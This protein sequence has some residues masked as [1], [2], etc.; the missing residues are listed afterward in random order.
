MANAQGERKQVTVLF[1]DISGFTALSETLD[2]E[3]VTELVNRFFGALNAPI[4]KYDGTI[5][6]FMGDAVMV[7]F[8]APAAHE[9]DPERAIRC[10]LEMRDAFAAEKNAMRAPDSL[11]LHIGI[12]T[13]L[14]V[15][16]VVGTESK[17]EYTVIGDTVN[18]ASRLKDQAPRGEIYVSQD[19]YRF[20]ERL[21]DFRAVGSLEV[22][23]KSQP[24]PT[25]QVVES[26]I[27]YISTR[28]IEGL[29]SPLVGRDGERAQL[30]RCFEML[31]QGRGQIAFLV[32]EAGLGKSRLVAEAKAEIRDWRL[33]DGKWKMEVGNAAT[34]PTSNLQ[35]P[36]SS[37]QWL[38]GRSLSHTENVAYFPIIEMLK[39]LLGLR[40][41]M[42]RSDAA[43]ALDV[44]GAKYFS[45][46]DC[47]IVL[48]ILKSLLS[49][50]LDPTAR[51][52]LRYL[53]AEGLKR[54][55]FY[56][57]RQ[58]L[59]AVA[60]TAPA[61]VFMEDL[62]W[63][64][65]S[66]LELLRY[67][68]P[69][70]LEFPLLFVFPMRPEREH[71]SWKLRQF[72]LS[73]YAARTTEILL[74]PLSPHAAN[75]LLTN[76]LAIEDLPASL[77]DLI[78]AHAEGNPFYVE[79]IVRSMIDQKMIEQVNLRWRTTHAIDE[80]NLPSTL[81][82]VIAARIDRLDA[83]VKETLQIGSVIGR[84]FPYAVLARLVP[85]SARLDADL[86]RLQEMALIFETQERG[87]RQHIFK[88][89]LTQ[90]AAYETLLLRRRRELHGQIARA[91]QEYFGARVEDQIGLV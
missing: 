33:E 5:D 65:D 44:W 73:D 21:F 18:L 26:K 39:R 76:L 50:D 83:N 63:A 4:E 17:R 45:A 56:A 49:L 74:A 15:A 69:Q 67:L 29:K 20:T 79:E 7:L 25:F 75:Q 58:G 32:G 31:A 47:E 90:E 42:P 87:E 68:L 19:T 66:S 81:A 9:N 38:E 71:G 86:A 43:H 57:I 12:N 91:L 35:L 61:V 55:T 64:D 80:L 16:G 88:H 46:S 40:E 85:D 52:R 37:L 70:V 72:A 51:D 89:I 11:A 82:G 62:H 84:S 36:T 30:M 13:G 59:R 53:D 23:G 3:Q 60:R 34:R 22:K 14:A 48:P 6:K 8:G 10:A 24:V 77:R 2:P 78:L 41:D 28:G 54:Q 1:A 27:G